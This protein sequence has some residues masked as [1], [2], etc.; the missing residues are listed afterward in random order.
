MRRSAR[1]L[2]V[3][4]FWRRRLAGRPTRRLPCSSTSSRG[5]E[6]RDEIGAG[7]TTVIIPIGGTEQNGPHMALGKHNVRVKALAGKIALALAQRAGGAGRELCPRRQH[8]AADGAHALSRNH[9]RAR[10]HVRAG[11]RIGGAELSLH[12]FRDIVF[13]GDHGGISKEPDGGRRPPQPRMGGVGGARACD[14]RVLPDG[15]DRLPAHAQEPRLRR[16]RDRHARGARRHLAR[17]GDRP[18]ARTPRQARFEATRGAADGV[19]AIRA[20]RRP[21]SVSSASMRS[22]PQPSMRSGAPPSGAEA[23]RPRMNEHPAH[24]LHGRRN[25]R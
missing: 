14:R 9:H 22:S 24:P 12:G 11:A 4:V 3:P 13:I 5:P 8:R 15:G 2:G 23:L 10:S 1:W 19:A 18:G 16:R 7:K 20:G 21:S 25:R 17:P 6:L